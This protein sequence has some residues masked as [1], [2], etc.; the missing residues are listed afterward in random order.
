MNLNSDFVEDLWELVKPL[1]NKDNREEFI[2]K[3]FI[4]LHDYGVDSDDLK[5]AGG[6]DAI[7]ATVW[8]NMY[9]DPDEEF[10]ED[11]DYQNEFED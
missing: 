10:Y 11:D 5:A 3:L 6:E 7:L 2:E 9:H 8:T 4:T 1:I